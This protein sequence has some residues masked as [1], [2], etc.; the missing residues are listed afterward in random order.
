MARQLST[1]ALGASPNREMKRS[2]LRCELLRERA[3]EPETAIP[4]GT[5][6]R[7]RDREEIEATL[8]DVKA[9]GLLDLDLSYGGS[10]LVVRGL[11]PAGY[12]YLDEQCRPWL[13]RAWSGVWRRVSVGS[14]IGWLK[15]C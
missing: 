12:S 7:G 13:A 15:G 11:T 3:A 1:A 8:K 6:L 2:K 9:R 5:F 14:V 4:F 10:I